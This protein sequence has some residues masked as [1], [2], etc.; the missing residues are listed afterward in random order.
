MK[1]VRQYVDTVQWAML[2][3]YVELIAAITDRDAEFQAQSAEAI[4]RRFGSFVEGTREATVRGSVGILP[5][6]GPLFRYANLFTA[7]SGATSFERLAA[8]LG[9]LEDDP[10]VKQIVLEVN[11]PGGEV[12]GTAETAE[13]IRNAKK[14]V[15][16]Y[17]SHLGASA[18][19]WVAAAAGKVYASPTA[20]AGSVG[21]VSRLRRVRNRD[22]VQEIEIVSS[23]TPKK[24]MDAFAEDEEGAKARAE[25]QGRVDDMAL[26]FIEAVANYRGISPEQVMAT[27][28][29]MFVGQKAVEAGFVDGITTLENLIQGLQGSERGS[30]GPVLY[31]AGLPGTNHTQEEPMEITRAFLEENH[32]DLVAAIRD[33][34]AEAG[35]AE[36]VTAGRE[37]ERERILGI[38]SIPAAGFEE[39]QRELM[40]DPSVTRG[41][42][43]LRILD[44]KGQQESRRRQAE[45][46]NLNADEAALEGVKTTASEGEVVEGAEEEVVANAILGHVKRYQTLTAAQ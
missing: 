27:E 29:G 44:A 40:A 10:R 8:D 34:G 22:N 14:P 4:E 18:G 28:G 9:T 5:V 24:R 35:R 43:A 46:D 6:T 16:S 11:S 2:E 21:V 41:E 36:G 26:V 45:K 32:A 12:D 7:M 3:E 13:L 30:S 17:I 33:E 20:M 23:M 38:M 39:M 42:A 1:L 19:L 37:Q 15:T 25:I 31:S